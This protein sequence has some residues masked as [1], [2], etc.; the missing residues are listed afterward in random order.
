MFRGFELKLDENT[1]SQQVGDFTLYENEG[2]YLKTDLH[3]FF[4][5]NIQKFTYDSSFSIDGNEIENRW[6]PKSS[7][8]FHVFLSHSHADEQLALAI[9]GLL[10]RFGICVFV[11]S[12]VWG[13]RDQLIRQLFAFGEKTY[14]NLVSM[15]SHV[16]CMLMKSLIEMMDSCECL[17]FLNTPQSISAREAV[18]QTHSPWIYAELEA[19]RFLRSHPDP[20]RTPLQVV[21]ENFSSRKKQASDRANIAYNLP[22]HL[23]KLSIVQFRQWMKRACRKKGFDALNELYKYS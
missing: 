2:E 15:C 6:F 5:R 21:V 11:D 17:L 13:F 14:P 16:D 1:F 19:S 10:K 4:G 18:R 7:G 12:L 8:L 9:T 20:A 3:A 23:T 22:E